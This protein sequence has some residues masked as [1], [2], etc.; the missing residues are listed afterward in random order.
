MMVV[1]KPQSHALGNC[2][3]IPKNHLYETTEEDRVLSAV[4]E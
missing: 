1:S 4:E 3:T 2:Q